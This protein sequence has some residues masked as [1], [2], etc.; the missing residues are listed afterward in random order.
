MKTPGERLPHGV[1]EDDQLSNGLRRSRLTAI[2]LCLTFGAILAVAA[3]DP[4]FAGAAFAG[5]A[6]LAVLA[7][8]AFRSERRPGDEGA[9]Q[10]LF[11]AAFDASPALMILLGRNGQPEAVN[12]AFTETLG[13]KLDHF[14]R[15]GWK[16]IIHADD[17][18]APPSPDHKVIKRLLAADGTVIRGE[19]QIAP[20]ADSRLIISID[21]RTSR[22]EAEEQVRYQASLLDQVTNAVL[23]VDCQ[24]GIVYANRAAIELFH[25]DQTLQEIAVGTLLGPEVTGALGHARA[26]IETEGTNFSGTH[27]P[28]AV[29]LARIVD[30]AGQMVGTVL[31]VTDLTQRRAM[32]MQLM[33]S[34]RLATLGEMSASIAHEF[35]Q[36]LHVIRLSSEALT[37]D[38][39]D[40]KLEIAR[41]DKRANNIL[42]QVDR[43][44]EMV[45][46]MR[47]ISRRES[48]GK[49]AFLPQLAVDGAI[50]MTEPLMVT[51]SIRLERFGSL[52]NATTLGHQVR[53]EQVMI[54]LLNNARDAIHDRDPDARTGGVVT[55]TCSADDARRRLLI[56]VRDDGSGVPA[57][58]APTIFDPFVTTKDGQ[59]GCGLGLSISRGII[60]EMGGSLTFRNTLPG[61]EFTVEL[62]MAGAL[63]DELASPLPAPQLL[64][65]ECDDDDDDDEPGDGRRVLLVDDEALSVMMLGE[66]LQRL[67]YTVDT[68]YDGE[69]AL[70]LCEEHVYDTVI[71]DIRMPRM[72]GHKLIRALEDL[73]PGTPVI[74]VTGH[75]KEGSEAELGSNVVAVLAKPFQLM[76]L[77]RHL[78]R[79]ESGEWHKEREGV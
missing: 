75:I 77:R 62:P 46:Q 10:A 2:G 3:P 47:S 23:G 69:A 22:W 58:V 33:H 20:V 34:A 66:F 14:T 30:E 24:G 71:T 36:C 43:L 56:S 38:L 9:A 5:S 44:T 42:T 76:I 49:Q 28:A 45:M 48:G 78:D 65:D 60:Q 70:H 55:V 12:R 21:D 39:A 53:L 1:R 32:D 67:G 17:R 51:E 63:L 50:R 19:I 11:R 16:A 64:P 31:V 73:Q 41:V 29:N 8:L 52:D 57:E 74:V 15:L 7:G 27:F 25:W 72:D 40:G 59:R 26:E 68:A 37:M 4:I 13:Y 61:A 79:I 35:N 54:N 6:G 18:G